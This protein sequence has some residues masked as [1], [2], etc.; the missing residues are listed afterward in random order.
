MI[1]EEVF[2]D[3]FALHRQGHSM[4]FIAKKLGL[5]RNTVKKHIVGKRFP[6]YRRSGRRTSILA[7]YVRIIADWL[8]Q[9]NYRASWIF[10]RLKQLGYTGGYDTVKNFVRPFK[11]CPDHRMQESARPTLPG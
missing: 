4:R 1:T 9:D 11:A 3:I 5:H 7:P 6:E 10:E 8:S 2:M